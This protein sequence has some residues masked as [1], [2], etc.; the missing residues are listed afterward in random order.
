MD[1]LNTLE[2]LARK[3]NGNAASDVGVACLLA[4][5]AVKGALFNV[6]INVASLPREMAADVIEESRGMREACSQVAKGVM[7]AVHDRIQS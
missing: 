4:S 2:D 5:A 1:L 3:G 6:E 7:H